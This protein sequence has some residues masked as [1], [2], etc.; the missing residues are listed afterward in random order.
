M[1]EKVTKLHIL[2]EM[3]RSL[4]QLPPRHP[5]LQCHLG[6]RISR[7]IGIPQRRALNAKIGNTDLEL[8]K[9]IDVVRYRVTLGGPRHMMSSGGN[10]DR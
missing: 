7:D 9:P 8:S 6:A 10:L 4:T 2:V 5:L 3:L 1:G